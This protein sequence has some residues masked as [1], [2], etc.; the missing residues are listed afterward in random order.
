MFG[1]SLKGR[2]AV[3]LGV[4]SVVQFDSALICL[5]SNSNEEYAA[6]NYLKTYCCEQC[7]RS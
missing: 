5:K 4:L 1:K 2:M 6:K 7:C 3:Y